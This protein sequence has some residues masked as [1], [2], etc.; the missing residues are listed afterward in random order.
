M[1]NCFA[2]L[3]VSTPRQG[4]K[5]VSLQEQRDDIIAN[6]YKND[7]HISEWFE[8][9]ESAAKYGGRPVFTDMVKKL[10][11]KK[12]DGV[13]FHKIDR[14]SRNMSDWAILEELHDGGCEIHFTVDNLDLHSLGDRMV[15][16]IQ[17]VMAANYSRN[18][19][20]EARKGFKGRLKQGIYPLAAPIGYL[21]M[22]G[23]KVKEIDPV[24][25]PLMRKAF[26]L[27][28]TGEYTL[29]DI[30]NRLQ[31]RPKRSGKIISKHALSEAFKNPFYIG[32]MRII[33][34]GERYKGKHEPLISQ[35]LFNQVQNVLVGKV[36]RKETR[37]TYLFSRTF[38]CAKCGYA[39]TP[40]KQKVF[41][42]YRCHTQKC[43]RSTIK[44]EELENAVTEF[45]NSLT[46]NAVGLKM[47]KFKIDQLLDK[48][49]SEAKH[50][51]NTVALRQSQIINQLNRLTDIFVEGAIEKDVFEERRLALQITKSELEQ[52]SKSGV[53]PTE[54]LQHKVSEFFEQLES[55]A[56][57]QNLATDT[58]KV[59][60][61]KS[62][63]SNRTASPENVDFKP[64]KPWQQV[65][66]YNA[67][68]L[69]GHE[70]TRLRTETGKLARYLFKYFKDLG[71]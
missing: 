7:L 16:G 37:H 9:R 33:S 3:R 19:R 55:V 64:R 34:T 71:P 45:L 1:K 12:A 2:Y 21:D 68:M 42:Y 17:A 24:N 63:T 40:E 51:R 54:K 49:I 18:L 43:L 22:G 41:I 6:A 31:M 23:G 62:V 61:L 4:V 20:Q 36:R 29:D 70:R 28:A 30:R 48:A 39:L 15:A 58:E 59:K 53:T 32:I 69:C 67:V 56:D 66:D 65:Q 44:E 38:K 47:L 46:I 50:T 5:G 26:E 14:S 25:G 35:A 10:K 57:S 27:Y 11:S 8:E 13:I 60:L 52:E